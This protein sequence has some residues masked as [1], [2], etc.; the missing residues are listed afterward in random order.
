MKG[1]IG[2]YRIVER[3][4]NFNNKRS[5]KMQELKERLSNIT[6]PYLSELARLGSIKVSN[7]AYSKSFGV[8]ESG[9]SFFP[10]VIERVVTEIKLFDEFK[11]TGEFP[12]FYDS[13]VADIAHDS[14]TGKTVDI[15]EKRLEL[16]ISEIANG[17][18]PS[19]DIEISKIEK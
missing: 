11:I 4:E 8:D 18:E 15:K 16:I 12:E 10:E 2:D 7:T 17:V 3:N 6:P 9:E 5:N 14:L 1:V 19:I 13:N